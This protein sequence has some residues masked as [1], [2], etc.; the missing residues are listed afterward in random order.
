[1]KYV[2]PNRFRQIV[3]AVSLLVILGRILQSNK[4]IGQQSADKFQSYILL[5]QTASDSYVIFDVNVIPMTGEIILPH[6][7]VVIANHRI[8]QI[9]PVTATPIP[10][11]SQLIDGRN[12][13]LMPGLADMHIH[14]N[15][16]YY[17]SLLVANGITTVR[18]MKGTPEILAMRQ[19]IANGE[20][21]GPRIYTA[22]PILNEV[23]YDQP[24]QRILSTLDGAEHIVAE[25]KADG[26]DFIKVYDGLSGSAYQNVTKAA[27]EFGIKV[28]G[29]VPDGMSVLQIIEAGQQSIEHLDGY[30]TLE[31]SQLAAIAQQTANA[32]VWNCP[33]ITAFQ[34]LQPV[35]GTRTYVQQ[36]MF[37]YIPTLTLKIWFLPKD[38][39]E[40][41]YNYASI[42]PVQRNIIQ[43]LHKAGALL[44]AGTDAPMPCAVPG[45][46]LQQELK[47]LTE[48]GL[49]AYEALQTATYNPARF[50]NTLDKFGT[51]TV[52]SEADLILLNANPLDDVANLRQIDGVMLQGCW[53]SRAQLDEL[54]QTAQLAAAAE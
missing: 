47:N 48:A 31:E 34:P 38:F 8:L 41:A 54:L 45:F 16:E 49:T 7:T 46:A 18:N 36:E 23:P 22:G 9:A 50:L 6:Q 1:M 15:R 11:G 28:A 12:H 33:T 43:A 2:Y 53:L 52:G 40:Q 27:Q 44:L 51:V 42:N 39:R 4:A 32:G 10:A 30:C 35:A 5:Q 21:L 29:H 17:L 37:D 25:Q 20:L 14:L 13:Y 3:C 24:S 26:Y 19:R